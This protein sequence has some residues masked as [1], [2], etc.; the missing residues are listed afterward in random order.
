M[1]RCSLSS[2][3]VGFLTFLIVWLSRGTAAEAD[4]PLPRPAIPRHYPH[5]R[6]A[7]LAYAGT[8]FSNFEDD[9][10]RNSVDLVVP[11]TAY[12]ERLNK[13]APQT[14]RLIYTNTSNLYL[15]LL[16]DWLAY[17]DQRG[18]PREAAF[19]H[20]A[21]PVPFR[22]DSPSSRAVR[23]FWNIARGG[24][25]L[26]NLT[27]VASTGKGRVAFGAAGESLYVGYPERFRE[28]NVTLTSGAEAGW[29]AA[30]E[31]PSAVDAT[32]APTKWTELPTRG[33]STRGLK[34]AGKVTFDPPADWKTTSMGGSA[35]LFHVRYRT[36]QG[37]T[38]PV[39]T[40]LWGRDYVEANGKAAGTIP[41]FDAQADTNKDGHLDDQE[42][43][44]RAPG[45]EARFL[46]ESRLWTESYGQMRPA[47]NPSSAAF[48]AWGVDYHVR[49]L[50]KHP[51]AS[52]LFMDNANGKPLVKA[53]EVLE[54]LDDYGADCGR[55][56]ADIWRA[57]APRWVLANTGGASLAGD[58]V[59]KHSPAYFEEFGIRPLSHNWA[60]FEDLAALTSRRES[61]GTPAPL[62]VLD[63]HP[64]RGTI[65]DAR[66]QLSVLA[67]YYLLADPD[68]TFL[69]FHGGFEPAGSWTRHW[70]PAV[71]YNIGKPAGKWSQRATGPDPSNKDL[72]YRLYQREYEKALVL[73]KPLS[74]V[75]GNRAPV[76]VG[77]DTATKHDL[78]GAYR[79]LLAGGTLGEPLRTI[80]LRNGEGAILIKGE[81]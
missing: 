62:A 43:A 42:Y 11:N 54:S 15:D 52:G 19:Y 27:G 64:Q 2:L 4:P 7:M 33:D 5:I 63:S 80:T 77:D 23:M 65:N 17:A 69:V 30:L 70:S 56:L 10:L 44:K 47:T 72:S 28:I 81:K 68:S 20:A 14:P 36:T 66:M 6:I 51:L 31:Y 40:T 3:M 46:Y 8:P 41:V 25:T 71:T 21:R 48:R 55:L 12:L 49:Y 58:A 1:K 45:K 9:L 37:G 73:Y 22:G 79:L 38:V 16:T 39:A 59:V 53:G 26:T 67:Y 74:H 60:F 13:V 18:Q 24:A 50:A 61:L 29:S 32:G 35:R 76:S 75:R 34:Q 57:I 78:G